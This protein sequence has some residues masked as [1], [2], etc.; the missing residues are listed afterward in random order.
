MKNKRTLFTT[1]LLFAGTLSAGAGAQSGHGAHTH[2]E[3]TLNAIRDRGTV[4][5]AINLPGADVVGFEHEAVTE[6]DIRSVRDALA[7]LGNVSR[8]LGLPRAADC[9]VH[10]ADV[11]TSLLHDQGGHG[12][13]HGHTDKHKHESRH[14]HRHEKDNRDGHGGFAAHYELECGS[15][16]ALD[17]IAINLFSLFPSLHKVDAVMVTNTRQ[18]AGTLTASENTISLAK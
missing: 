1:V 10:D 5:I 7:T 14:E 2:G 17:G 3:G 16:D 15:P 9:T 8:V 13:G 12:D 6:A 4:A 18:T 11:T